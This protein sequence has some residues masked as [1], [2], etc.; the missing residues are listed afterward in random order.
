MSFFLRLSSTLPLIDPSSHMSDA[1]PQLIGTN[2]DTV[3]SKFTP[4]TAH[5][6]VR[7]DG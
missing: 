4:V 3:A 6:A 7:L 5:F 2:T 1:I